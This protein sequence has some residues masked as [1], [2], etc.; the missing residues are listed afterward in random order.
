MEY[1]AEEIK[2]YKSEHNVFDANNNNEAIQL[3]FTLQSKPML[4][5]WGYVKKEEMPCTVT[6]MVPSYIRGEYVLTPVE[7][8]TPNE[9]G[10][11]QFQIEKTK[12]EP[13]VEITP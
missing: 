7:S 5:I 4:R 12:A 3:D 13:I 9:S 8:V 6:L 11:Y 10:Y 1:I 2:Y